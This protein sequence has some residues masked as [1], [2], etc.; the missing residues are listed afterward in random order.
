[1]AQALGYALLDAAGRPLPPG[2]AALRELARIDASGAHPGFRFLRVMGATDVTNPLCGPEGASAIYGPQ[3]GA[4]AAA[5]AELDEALAHFASIVRRDLGVDVAERPGAGAAG[6]LGAGLIAFL[7]AELLSGARVVA[8]AAGLAERAARAD[9][10]IT[11]EGRLDEQT[12][13]GKTPQFVAQVAAEVGRPVV[14]LA[15]WIDGSYDPSK[16]AFSEVEAL[17]DGSGPLPT[18]EEAA[19]QLAAAAV[20]ALN[21]LVDRGL[22]VEPVD[23]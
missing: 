5:I 15:G 6:G 17:S 23:L 10:V 4:D 13:F 9:V 21:R 22:V 1:M 2:G 7:G 11:G 12:A 18:M 16:S 19:E 14:C 3:K 8:E 20:R